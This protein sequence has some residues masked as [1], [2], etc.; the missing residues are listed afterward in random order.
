MQSEAWEKIQKSE[1]DT[2][3]KSFQKS[4]DY[5]LGATLERRKD[6]QEHLMEFS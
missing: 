4:R 2:G 5:E 6:G 3:K 1:G